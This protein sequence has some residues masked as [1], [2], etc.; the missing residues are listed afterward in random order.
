MNGIKVEAR[1]LQQRLDEL[2]DLEQRQLPYVIALSLTET[3][4]QVK[5]RLELEMR[6]VFD[7]PTRWTLNS[8]RLFPLR[9]TSQS[10]ASG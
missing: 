1:G 10:P 6:T 4:K 2:T 8:L 7:R 9:K 5:D 3:A